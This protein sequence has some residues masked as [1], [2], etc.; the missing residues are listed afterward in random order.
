MISNTFNFL[1]TL[2][3]CPIR[4]RT[5]YEP[6]RGK[7]QNQYTEVTEGRRTVRIQI[8]QSH[9]CFTEI[10]MLESPASKWP[11]PVSVTECA[12][13]HAEIQSSLRNHV[14]T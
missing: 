14:I 2:K 7:H 4:W 10:L 12:Q 8:F 9:I 6:L 3:N 11:Q 13:Q 1:L 5:L